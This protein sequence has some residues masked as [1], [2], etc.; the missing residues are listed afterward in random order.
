MSTASIDIEDTPNPLARKFTA[1]RV[2][3]P[4]PARSYRSAD[5]AADD[6]LAA[7]LFA[8]G[9]VTSVLIVADFVTVNKS[10]AAR[11][12]KLQPKLEAVLRAHLNDSPPV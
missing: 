1:D 3:N 5:D 7:A 2:L 8:A 10:P 9:P 11:W 12:P 4:G 6:P